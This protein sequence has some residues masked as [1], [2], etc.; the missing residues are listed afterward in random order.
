LLSF[1]KRL[2][3]V[4]FPFFVFQESLLAE[5]TQ[6]GQF[7]PY[8]QQAWSGYMGQNGDA[9]FNVRNIIKTKLGLI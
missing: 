1:D 3:K 4:S 2:L 5:N 6:C 9:R 8:K 7:L